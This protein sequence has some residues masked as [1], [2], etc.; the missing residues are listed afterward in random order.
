MRRVP[1]RMDMALAASACL[2]LAACDSVLEVERPNLVTPDDVTGPRG[3]E[4]F[5][6]GA[7]GEFANAFG[8]RVGQVIVSGLMA[9]EF[10]Y[11]NVFPQWLDVD[12]RD[13]GESNLTIPGVYARLHR[14]RVALE[15]AADMAR[16]NL[17]GTSTEAEMLALAGY[18]YVFFG[19]HFCSGVPFG[20]ALPGGETTL[21][22]QRSTVETFGI[23][24]ERFGGAA[25]TAAE[26]ADLANL[27]AVGAARTLMDLGRFD[28]AAARVANV[29]TD[30]AYLVR[31]KG[32]ADDTQEN[33]VYAE[34]SVNGNISL[35]DREGGNGMP[36]R[37]A[38]DPRLGWIH[39][40]GRVGANNV[41]PLYE[42][43][44]YDSFDD[45]VV[46]A[47]GLEARLIEA[48][49][50][51]RADDVALMLAKLN[52]LRATRSLGDLTDPGTRDARIDLLFAERAW[53]MFGT[54]HRLGDLR[55]L[56]RQYGR[57]AE[58]IFPTGA[59][60]ARGGSYGTDVNL[61]IP[62]DENANPN[63]AGCFD[64]GA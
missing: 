25:A 38:N 36:F 35:S 24:L 57:R 43:T 32:G 40:E 12:A 22:E 59:Y 23:A 54:A 27:A 30:W 34:N 8:G 5:A 20:R 29:P 31:Y 53:W 2:A 47:D 4:L 64:R 15:N 3:A 41:D 1:L 13:V 16:E 39:A 55:R 19:E 7:R 63:Y 60:P 37:S 18:T 9:D 45:D 56:I 61:I 6:A 11:V 10:G 17:P 48:E 44:K 50:A 26:S 49:A 62:D 33:K 14:A 42:Q 58:A 28:E 51:L 21:G 46:L 52:A